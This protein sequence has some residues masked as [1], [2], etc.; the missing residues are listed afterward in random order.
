MPLL[1]VPTLGLGTSATHDVGLSI[2]NV[3]Q[4]GTGGYLAAHLL[5]GGG[6]VGDVLTLATGGATSEWATPSND[7]VQSVFFTLA[8]D[9][10]TVTLGRTGGL[11]NI[12]STP[13]TLPSGGGGGD[14]TGVTAG[15]G[16]SGGGD[17]GAVTL[18]LTFNNLPLEGSILEDDRL[19]FQDI[20]DANNM[21]YITKGDFV[22]D[23][24]DGTSLTSINGELSIN[25][26][27]VSTIHLGNLAVT[28][29][30]IHTSNS[31]TADDVLQ[32]DGTQMVWSAT[33]GTYGDTEVG[34][35]LLDR[36]QNAPGVGASFSDRVLVW[37]DGNP[38]ELRSTN[39]GGA[40]NYIA[41]SWA[42]PT[43]NDEIPI[44]KL[45]GWW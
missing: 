26:F 10:L 1:H 14:I 35:Y 18:A 16:L 15:L 23:V 29:P 36:L 4:L 38:T 42:H 5:A 32:W 9:D 12:S 44:A 21:K 33:G 6:I 39:W 27:G 19:A 13:I 8:G 2:N 40:R 17:T 43:N 41:A 34:V 31:P 11:A 28:Q 30:K 20:S 24:A 22:G 45:A 37:D 7:Y 3:P 25:S